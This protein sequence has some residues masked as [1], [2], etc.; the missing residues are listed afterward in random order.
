VNETTGKNDDEIDSLGSHQY[1][2]IIALAMQ[3]GWMMMLT[4]K[5]LC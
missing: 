3:L 2:G 4:V 1:S 5:S